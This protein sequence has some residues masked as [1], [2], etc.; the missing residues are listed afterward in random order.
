[1]IVTYD[2]HGGFFD[3]V[4]PLDIKDSAGG[5]QFNTTGVRVPAFVVSPQVSPGKPFNGK[6]DHTSILQLLADRF[7]PGQPYSAAVTARQKQLDPLSA[8]FVPLPAQVPT[9]AFPENIA[10]A[11]HV[12]AA[13]APVPPVGPGAPRQTETAE[14]FNR[15][16]HDL[17]IKRPDLL[18]TPHGQLIAEYVAGTA[19]TGGTLPAPR[20]VLSRRPAKKKRAAKS[21]RVAK[22]AQAA[23]A[24]ERETG[25]PAKA[26]LIGSAPARLAARISLGA[27]RALGRTPRRR[28]ADRAPPDAAARAVFP[29]A[30]SQARRRRAARIGRGAGCAPIA[31]RG[32]F[33]P[34]RPAPSPGSLAKAFFA[35]LTGWRSTRSRRLDRRGGV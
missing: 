16:A 26:V 13:T 1:M 24:A 25:Q 31:A 21:K 12:L 5:K 35:L 34:T 15:V 8:V 28:R 2:E 9:P 6:L 33:Y 30:V 18:T 27:D 19:P 29:G 20:A 11:M 14:A 10:A 7:T 4:P 32:S 3:H 23:D 22:G 17:A